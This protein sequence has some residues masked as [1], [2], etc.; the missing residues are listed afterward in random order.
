MTGHATP[1]RLI[2]DYHLSSGVQRIHLDR[3]YQN[4]GQADEG[5]LRNRVVGFYVNG[6]YVLL[7]R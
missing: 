5:R 4:R 7:K 6:V 3:I 2:Y 1:I